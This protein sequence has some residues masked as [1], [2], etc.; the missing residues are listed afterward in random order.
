[1][2]REEEIARLAGLGERPPRPPGR[3]DAGNPAWRARN[4]WEREARA[5]AEEMYRKRRTPEALAAALERVRSRKG[6]K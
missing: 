4:A 2:R 5:L 6:A 3:Y 1:M